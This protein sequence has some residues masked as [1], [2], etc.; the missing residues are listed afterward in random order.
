MRIRAGACWQSGAVSRPSNTAAVPQRRR[1]LAGGGL[2]SGC[3]HGASD[4]RSSS[5]ENRSPTWYSMRIRT[6]A[7]GLEAS[8][9][10]ASRITLA[11]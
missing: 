1:E 9:L 11:R 7:V 8:M 10:R 3:A 2:A 5:R 4:H 6:V